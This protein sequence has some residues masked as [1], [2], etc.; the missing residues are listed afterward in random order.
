MQCCTFQ[1]SGGE[2]GQINGNTFQTP[3]FKCG[4]HEIR[5]QATSDRRFMVPVMGE[6]LTSARD[7]PGWLGSGRLFGWGLW[8][9]PKCWH[10]H[11]TASDH[12]PRGQGIV[13]NV[14]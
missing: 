10:R 5:T 6:P 14:I 9:P 7:R 1:S 8:G 13:N 4:A 2:E 12:R 3:T 11:N